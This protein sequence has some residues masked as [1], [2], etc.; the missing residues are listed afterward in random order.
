MRDAIAEDAWS[1][2]EGA[3][4]EL[5]EPVDA[6]WMA[7]VAREHLSPLNAFYRR[8]RKIEASFAGRAVGI[9]T[10]RPT[11]R[12]HP[13]RR[14]VM[15][16]RIDTSDGEV[17]V[18]RSLL[19]FVVATVE[20]QL[21][22]DRLSA[23]Q[24]AIILEFALGPALAVIETGLDCR[25]SL[26]DLHPESPDDKKGELLSLA[27][28]LE[29]AELGTSTLELALAV[30]ETLRL[31]R[32]LDRRAGNEKTSTENT[33][34]DLPFAVALRVAAATLTIGEV[35]GLAHDHVILANAEAPSHGGAIAVIAEHLVAPVELTPTGALL[36][37]R[38]AHGL[39]SPW[40]WSMDKPSADPGAV[41]LEDAM[42]EDLP[43]RLV[44]EIG[45]IE[46]SLGEVQRL[47]PGALVPLARPLDE[48]LDIVANGRRLGRGTLVRIGQSLGVRIVS[49]IGDD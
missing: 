14:H 29:L 28:D 8:R 38:P 22:L 36:T 20:P 2:S 6:T 5:R 19:D 25:L 35:K 33:W 39:N 9:A 7:C 4:D 3:P 21:S 49:L 26:D 34:V 47:A 44:F 24:Q 12:E 32:Y 27:V 11:G 30:D 40:E 18:P 23:E 37:A 45:R 15:S 13:P 48:P 1:A 41:P 43:V 16:L 42:L 46:L 31:A 17:F 10:A